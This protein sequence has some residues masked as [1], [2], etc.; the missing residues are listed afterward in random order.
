MISVLYGRDKMTYGAEYQEI[1]DPRPPGSHFSASPLIASKKREEFN[2]EDH[3]LEEKILLEDKKREARK[4][5]KKVL[6]KLDIIS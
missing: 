4:R 5:K 3:I 1:D 2:L 6:H